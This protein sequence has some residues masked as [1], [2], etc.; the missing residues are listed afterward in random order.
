MEKG[1]SFVVRN[2]TTVEWVCEEWMGTSSIWIT[3]GDDP[4]KFAIPLLLLQ[5]SFVSSFSSF[6]QYLLRPFGNFAFLTQTLGGILLGPSGLA[7]NKQFESKVY[8]TR[9]LFIIENYEEIC[10]LFISFVT[11]AQLDTGMIKRGGKLAF[12]NGICLFMLSF[13]AANI[14]AYM[15][16]NVIGV[17]VAKLTAKGIHRMLVVESTLYFQGAYTVLSDLKMLNTEPGRLALS[18][19]MVHNCFAWAFYMFLLSLNS[20]KR[21]IDFDYNVPILWLVI[22][23]I[24]MIVGIVWGCRP[25]LEWMARKTPEGQMIKGTYVCM[26]VLMLLVSTLWAEYVGLPFFIGSVVMGLSTP[27]RPVLASVL[28][29]KIGCFV[30]AVLMPCNTIGIGQKVD[31]SSFSTRE[32]LVTELMLMI[33]RTAKFLAIVGP[34]FYHKVPLPHAVIA[35]FIVN[36]QGIYDVQ[37]YKQNLNYKRITNEAFSILVL[38]TMLSSTIII[39]TVRK[40]YDSMNKRSPYKRRRVQNGRAGAPL[41]IL[42]CFRN[43]DVVPSVLNVLELSR[44]VKG[45][46]PLSAFTLNLEELHNHCVPLLIHHGLHNF[47]Y[48][49]P[50]RRDQIVKAFRNY[51]RLS[52]ETVCIECFTSMAPR[53]T[54]HDDVC[55]IAY[56]NETD[57]VIMTLDREAETWE[58]LLCRNIL[59]NSPCSV[60]IHMDRGRLPDF[61]FV[62]IKTL[63]IKICALFLGGPDDREMLAYATR[64]SYHPS[65]K[66]LVLRLVD[67]IGLS[68]LRDLEETKLDMRSINLFCKEN[69]DRENITYKEARTEENS[70]LMNMLREE[71]D[72]YD[73]IMV[74]IRHEEGLQLLKGL[75]TWSEMEELGVI[76][77]LVVSRDLKLT[78]SVIAVHQ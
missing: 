18:S 23:K 75:S 5:I 59:E 66:L 12:I 33:I 40:M 69:A 62:P 43:R 35:G 63:S 44:P 14:T 55:A 3:R 10:F 32:A 67:Y 57:L 58:R 24:A 41:R 76:G 45:P 42:A 31:F 1:T 48:L 7:R 71:G 37:I 49:I 54:M 2:N 28:S 68:P 78:A 74:G 61:R 20:I 16:A 56:N 15:A 34:S 72:E 11:T 36:I 29:D 73:L 39:A 6:L 27:K 65:V 64:L 17:R 21:S 50:N 25:I 53:K 9:S 13:T 30:W 51:E 52:H 8:Y 19:M 4:T 22:P 47:P 38:S 70:E 60:A 77:D 26:I 46:P